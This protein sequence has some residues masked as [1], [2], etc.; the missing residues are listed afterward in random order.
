[1]KIVLV[2]LL[3][4]LLPG[5][6]RAQEAEEENPDYFIN[7]S[8]SDNDLF[9]DIVDTEES[10]NTVISSMDRS[11]VTLHASY[12]CFGGFSPGW[13]ELPW[14]P[15]EKDTSYVLGAKMEALLS[16]D[17]QLSKNLQV[18]NSF[19]FFIPPTSNSNTIFTL[20][21]FYID[22]NFND[23]LYL[24]AGQYEIAWGISPFYP[25]TNLPARIPENLIVG[26]SYIA[27]LDI[28]IGVGGLQILGMTRYGF[29]EDPTTPRF[30][31]IAF[32]SKYNLALQSADIDFGFFYFKEMPLRFFTSTKTTL[33][34]TELYVEGLASYSYENWEG[35][36]F[37]GN[38]GCIRDFV[39]GKLTLGAEIF[40]N[41]EPGAYWYRA[42][43]DIR[44]AE[45]NPL[46]EGLNGAFSFII[47]PGV[48]NMRIFGRLL[49]S[50][51]MNS[52]QI[53]PGISVKPIN[54]LTASLSVPMALGSRDEKSYYR[55]NEDAHNRPFSIVLGITISGSFRYRIYMD[56]SAE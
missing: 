7:D 44:D 27:K 30:R 39:N 5:F 4:F 25:F 40:Y 15:G 47:R 37:S 19:Y 3:L 49:Y 42:K 34:K 18:W 46:F 31:E 24:R 13:D 1:L 45:T 32:A 51:E 22:Y 28:P 11:R 48:L 2:I 9:S 26:D 12:N 38:V 33:G 14:L 56:R 55:H 8:F 53:V 35:V 23:Y 36:R 21:E 41:G 6:S 52:L 50:Y 43:D 29:M 17:F 10:G 20:K 54:Q 16:L